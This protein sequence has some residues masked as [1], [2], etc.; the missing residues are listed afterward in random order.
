MKQVSKYGG[1]GV[2]LVAMGVAA[3]LL[4]GLAA[5]A[6]AGLGTVLWVGWAP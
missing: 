2:E 4:V 1:A 5:L 6:G 3:V